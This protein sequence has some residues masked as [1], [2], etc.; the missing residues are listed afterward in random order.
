MKTYECSRSLNRS[1]YARVLAGSSIR[2]LVSKAVLR[3]HER[4]VRIMSDRYASADIKPSSEWTESL[5]IDASTAVSDLRRTGGVSEAAKRSD[6]Q[7]SKA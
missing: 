3:I 4:P 2:I 6:R 7:T 1:Q 5:K